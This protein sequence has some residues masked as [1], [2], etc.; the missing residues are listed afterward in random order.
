MHIKNKAMK[1]F[2]ISLFVVFA[3]PSLFAFQAH[4]QNLAYTHPAIVVSNTVSYISA[5][6]VPA[7]TT[8]TST[9]YWTP[10]LGTAPST[11]P[12]TPPTTEPST[13]D[14]N[15]SNLTPPED[16]TPQFAK[17]VGL[18]SR[19]FCGSL[20]TDP[21]IVG[22][23]IEGND[24]KSVIVT[25]K[26]PSLP[27]NEVANPLADPQLYVVDMSTG[28]VVGGPIDNWQDSSESAAITSSGR[29]PSSNLDSAVILRDLSSGAYSAICYGENITGT[30]LVEVYEFEDNVSV[31][32]KFLGLSTRGFCG[33]LSSDP[34]IVGFIVDGDQNTTVNLYIGAKGPS[35]P[36]SEVANPLS[37]PSLYIV[38]MSTG[39][40][41]AGPIDNWQDGADASTLIDVGRAPSDPKDAALILRDLPPGAYTAI[42]YGTGDV[43]GTVLVEAY[44]IDLD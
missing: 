8:I 15:L 24:S 1:L 37:D 32:S 6:N 22:F 26:G 31:E 30:A 21:L 38:D 2:S 29:A 4:N 41:I 36:S 25:A 13:S 28:G 10:L 18:S 19:G 39:G 14:S 7:G 11:D 35:L 3:L 12:G 44:E 9:T 16:T 43:T 27:T 42:A 40:V 34:R 5:Q 17:Q 20:A 33:S 23:I